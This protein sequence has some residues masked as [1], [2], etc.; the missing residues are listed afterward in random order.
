MISVIR[1]CVP[2]A[3][4]PQNFLLCYAP[5]STLWWHYDSIPRPGDQLELYRIVDGLGVGCALR[6]GNLHF[7][8]VKVG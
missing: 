4:T 6:N 5:L 7:L 8:V 2:E 1:Y 3:E